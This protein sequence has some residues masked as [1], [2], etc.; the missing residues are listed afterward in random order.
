MFFEGLGKPWWLAYL[1]TFVVTVIVVRSDGLIFA[2]GLQGR[3]AGL[4][5]LAVAGTV[6]V[7]VWFAL[8]DRYAVVGE[9]TRGRPVRSQKQIRGK[10]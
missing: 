10:R 6:A 4:V 5:A 7:A 8:R 9:D 2:Q 1:I 3:P